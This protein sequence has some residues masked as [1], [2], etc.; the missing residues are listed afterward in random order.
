MTRIRLG[1]C[2]G[3]ADVD[4]IIL[5]KLSVAVGASSFRRLR[6]VI[7]LTGATIS[8]TRLDAI[9]IKQLEHIVITDRA[10]RFQI[11]EDFLNPR[12]KDQ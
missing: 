1:E 6:T 3:E 8:D 10:L 9:D 4:D 12:I 7:F 5:S 11:S 2:K